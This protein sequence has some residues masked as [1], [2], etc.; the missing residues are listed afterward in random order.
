MEVVRWASD[1][2]H[3]IL[4]RLAS[5]SRVPCMSWLIPIIAVK[6]HQCMSFWRITP[7]SNTEARG[8]ITCCPSDRTDNMVQQL[9]GVDQNP[10]GAGALLTRT[11]R[12]LTSMFISFSQTPELVDERPRYRTPLVQDDICHLHATLLLDDQQSGE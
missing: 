3:S 2:S 1:G 12:H 5:S 4:L 11:P 10:L 8:K 7:Q 6:Q 9:A